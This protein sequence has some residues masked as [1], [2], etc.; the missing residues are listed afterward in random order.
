MSADAILDAQAGLSRELADLRWAPPVFRV[1]DPLTYAWEPHAAYVRRYAGTG[2]ILL[3]GM[4]PGPYG[5][6]QTGVPFGSVPMVRDFLRI[7]G[8]VGQ[9]TV[10]H[11]ARPILGFGCQRVEVSGAR[12][13]GW[14]QARF[15]T[16]EAFF[17]RFFVMNWCPL[18]FLEESGRNH[19]PEQLPRGEQ[20]A[21]FA[22][23]D[24]A[25]T[26]SIQALRPTLAVGVGKLAAARLAVAGA[27]RVGC[28]PHPSPASPTANRGWAPAAEAALRDLGVALG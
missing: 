17:A 20:R 18:L 26:R 24:A 23:C 7:S 25:L 2:Q 14:A 4:N 13:W 22:A 5:M 19:T 16:P 1:L 3:L 11:P 9:P 27:G 28:I 12:L 15:G 8:A 21:L 6:A 10:P